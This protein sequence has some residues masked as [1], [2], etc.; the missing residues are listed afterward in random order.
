MPRHG[1]A[2]TR[3]A[4]MRAFAKKCGLAYFQR[5]AP[6]V[7]AV[8][9]HQ[10]KNVE[11]N[12]AVMTAVADTLERRDAIVDTSHS[13]AVDNAGSRTQAGERLGH[14]REPACEVIAG[15]AIASLLHRLCER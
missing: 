6:H 15:P 1:Y 11:E 2:A 8:Q 13:L 7:V 3:E 9:L 14:E 4:A 10:V 5:I 12:V